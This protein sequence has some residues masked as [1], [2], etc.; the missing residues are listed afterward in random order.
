MTV[1]SARKEEEGEEAEEMGI[2][3]R[4]KIIQKSK[5]KCTLWQARGQ[6]LRME[7]DCEERAA[8]DGGEH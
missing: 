2:R 5:Q 7:G 8:E 4:K 1:T 6:R 3:G